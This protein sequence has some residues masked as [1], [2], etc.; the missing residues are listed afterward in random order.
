M[1][2]TTPEIQQIKHWLNYGNLTAVAIPFFDIALMFEEVIAPNLDTTWAEPYIRNTI[3]PN[4]LQLDIDIMACRTRFQ[5]LVLVGD[6]ELNP[7]ELDRLLDLQAYWIKQLS[8]TIKV[9]VA[10]G[11]GSSNGGGVILT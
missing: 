4:L 10:G 1:A 9:P 6:V 8:S 7:K 2:L 5:A 3:L 11:A